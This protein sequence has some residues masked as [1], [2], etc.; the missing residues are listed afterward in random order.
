MLTPLAKH[1]NLTAVITK[2]TASEKV[3]KLVGKSSKDTTDVTR[4]RRTAAC[5]VTRRDDA[6][7]ADF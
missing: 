2:Q 4:L 5:D 3:P 7:R 1:A 6:V